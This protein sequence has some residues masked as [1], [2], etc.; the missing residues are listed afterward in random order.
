MH[1]EKTPLPRGRSFA[2]QA[3]ILGDAL[4]AAGIDIETILHY[5]DT[6]TLFTAEFWPPIPAA[7]R[8]R[9][10][11][12]IGTVPSKAAAGTRVRMTHDVVPQ[13]VDWVQNL[14]RLPAN[15][16]RRS[17]QTFSCAPDATIWRSNDER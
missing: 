15:S 1:I 16:T 2:L 17:R 3:S 7:P 14:I 10:Y 8:D 12:V 13:F 4:V 11:I 9:L 5:R 6:R